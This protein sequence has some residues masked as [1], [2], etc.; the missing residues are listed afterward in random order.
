[1]SEGCRVTWGDPGHADAWGPS[2]L[3]LCVS[4]ALQ[5]VGA[6]EQSQTGS[7]KSVWVWGPH[8]ITGF[9]V[10]AESD[11]VLPSWH[12]QPSSR[13]RHQ[14]LAPFGVNSLKAGHLC[15]LRAQSRQVWKG[16]ERWEQVQAQTEPLCSLEK[17]P[18]EFL[19]RCTGLSFPIPK[20]GVLSCPNDLENCLWGQQDKVT[21]GKDLASEIPPFHRH[22][23]QP[24]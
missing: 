17:P 19:P 5:T 8:S 1:M 15:A 10:R 21:N 24:L 11:S 6:S 22:V 13:D 18:P 14:R 20:M 7:S 4:A 3:A 2:P 23:I 12:L 16:L 9:L